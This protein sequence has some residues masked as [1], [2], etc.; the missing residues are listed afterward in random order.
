MYR[1]EKYKNLKRYVS[2]ALL[3]IAVLVAKDPGINA[4]YKGDFEKAHH[5]YQERLKKDTDNEKIIYNQGTSA[6]AMEEYDEAKSLLMQ[7]LASDNEKQR[8][9][10]HYN[11]GKLTLQQ[12]ETDEAIAHFKKSMLYD[13]DDMNSK[14][15]Y[16]QLRQ[17]QQQQEQQKQDKQEGSDQQKQDDQQQSDQQQDQEQDQKQDNEKQDGQQQ[18]NESQDE[19]EQN[20]SMDSQLKEEDLT[21]QELSKEQAKNILNAMK[22][23]EKES[24]KKLILS[25]ARKKGIKRG[26]EW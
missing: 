18:D 3:S 25:K 22:E 8:A 6:L 4:F 10:A 19:Q 9:K 21:P 17:M 24:M 26:K 2:V 7:S 5:Y 23:D 11:L 14:I 20:K 15:M 1:K 13:P 16:E 12:Q